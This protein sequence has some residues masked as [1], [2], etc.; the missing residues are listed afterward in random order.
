M[1]SVPSPRPPSCS[2]VELQHPHEHWMRGLNAAA[3][4]PKS[5]RPVKA[6]KRRSAPAG[7]MQQKMEPQRSAD[8]DW[9]GHCTAAWKCA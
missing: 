4:W 3:Y 6:Q 8:V 2:R 1:F 7:A 9:K 5:H